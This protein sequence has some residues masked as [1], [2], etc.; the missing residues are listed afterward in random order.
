MCSKPSKILTFVTLLLLTSCATF[1]PS[2]VNNLCSVLADEDWYEAAIDSQDKWGTPI[3]V[4][5]AI[6]HQESKFQHDAQPPRKWYLGFIPGP[7]PS[8][9]YGYAQALE[10]TWDTYIR[11][12]GNSGADRDD[13]D[14]AIDFI[15]WYTATSHRKLGISKWDARAQYL[16]YHEGWGG[17]KRKTY[18]N[19]A[20]LLKVADKV[21]ARSLSFSNQYKQCRRELESNRGWF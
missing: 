7:R 8:N 11:A 2:N 15:G 12:T 18:N 20:W 17:Y 21:K 1:K 13:F 19:K 9:A 10:S 6:M 3:H 5:L 4:Q 16:A 14:D